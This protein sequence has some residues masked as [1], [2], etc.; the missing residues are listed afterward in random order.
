M[1]KTVVADSLTKDGR[2]F[3]KYVL[4]QMN[5]KTRKKNSRGR[6]TRSK[7]QRGENQEEKDNYL[8]DAIGIYDYDKVENALNNGA[9]VNAR[10]KDD[11]TPLIRAINSGEYDVIE[12]LL[13]NGADVTNEE[14][15]LAEDLEED[16]QDQSGIP[17]LIEYY[18]EI[19][20]KKD[21]FL[22]KQNI[23]AQTIP[24][25]LERQEDRKNL[26]MVMSEKDVGNVG[27]GTM[28]YELRHE[29]GKYLGGGKR[30]TRST[31]QN[32]GDNVNAKD[33]N[34]S[35]ALIRASWDG[36][37]EIVA[38]LLEKGADVNAKDNNGS[39]ALMKASL[40]GHT[41]VVSMLL[42]KGADVNAKDN[43]GSTALIKATLHRHTE[44]VR[45]LLEKGADVNVKSGYRSTALTLASWDG[46]TEIVRMLLEKGADVNAK[47]NNG[48]TAL[49]KASLNGHTKVVSMLLEKGA[50]VNAKNNAGNTA[51]FLAN[52]RFLENRPEYTEIVKLLKQS[53]A[54]QTFPKH[55]ERQEDRKN[56]AMVMSEKDVG[57]RGDGTM[58]LE[59]RHEIGK[60]LGGGKRK[61]R[62]SKKS[63]RKGRKT[64]KRKSKRKTK[65]KTRT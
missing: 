12:L 64:R 31:R 19:K 17:Y 13:E 36:D 40:N 27:D 32:G 63:N 23:V 18:I 26:A 47:D 21:D 62:K 16:D 37:T 15:S 35:T 24:K 38:M 9:N 6:K 14:Q 58:P 29:I 33:A 45:M 28:P 4:E 59:L 43:T 7:R 11:D 1:P 41:K 51:F 20:K 54:A 49:I 10:N 65:R 53:I 30:R 48:S 50:D 46:D 5:G 56:L 44:I 2:F 60:Y 52:R 42:E 22:L 61:T 3:T 34:G 57:N 8:F 55:L 25:V 39:T